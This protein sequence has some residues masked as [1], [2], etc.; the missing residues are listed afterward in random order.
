MADIDKFSDELDKLI[1]D[2]EN[3]LDDLGRL[4]GSKPESQTN[5]AT[6]IHSTEKNKPEDPF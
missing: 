3:Y 5:P 1:A 2:T 6:P 4:L